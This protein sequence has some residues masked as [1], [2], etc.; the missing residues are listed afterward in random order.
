MNAAVELSREVGVQAA[1]AAL[2]LPRA[3][4]YRTR[5]R[6]ESAPP[7]LSNPSSPLALPSETEQRILEV[8]HSERFMDA[9][10]YQIY[11]ALLDEGEY[12][13]SIRTMYRL[14]ARHGEVRE[15]RN[16]RRHPV[17]TQ[18]ELLASAANQV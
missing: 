10:P 18:P 7:T 15:R 3:R 12:L 4:F 8:L 11:P 14:L 2:G 5:A 9:S 17:Y 16:Q 6:I 1:C 13:C